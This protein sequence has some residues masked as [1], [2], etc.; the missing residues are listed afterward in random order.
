MVFDP[1]SNGS[2]I[3]GTT[4][5]LLPTNQAGTPTNNHVDLGSDTNK[6]K[7]LYLS[8]TANI[9]AAQLR[10]TGNIEVGG[11]NGGTDYGIVLTPAD[12]STHW[13]VYND[14][15]GH[16][17]FGDSGTVGSNEKMR[18]DSSGSLL[19]GKTSVDISTQGIV[20]R[21]G[22]GEAYFSRTNFTPIYVNRNTSD[23]DLISFRK[24]NTTVGSIMTNAGAFVFKGASASAP[25][26]LQT[27]DGN[28]DIEVDPDG[29]IKMETAGSC[30]L[31]TSPSPR[32]S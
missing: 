27:H 31:Y 11:Y 18:L 17:A 22:T 8:G 6:F 2:G 15:G 21:G 14:A 28:E 23:G 12:G 25:V 30:L 26:Q 19:V 1:R 5:G 9:G 13:H 3:T 7:D 29:F 20:L 16:L 32:D 4:N 10:A 24:D